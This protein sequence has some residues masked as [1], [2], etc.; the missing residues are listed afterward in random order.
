MSMVGLAQT[1]DLPATREWAPY[2]KAR[3]MTLNQVLETFVVEGSAIPDKTVA[4]EVALT[5]SAAMVSD[6]V[7]CDRLEA[8][9]AGYGAPAYELLRDPSA[10][11]EPMALG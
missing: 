2:D 5:C 4:S 10:A 7:V 3:D 6:S 9:C 11:T 8:S 1:N